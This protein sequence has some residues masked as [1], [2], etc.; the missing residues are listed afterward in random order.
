MAILGHLIPAGGGE[1]VP[2]TSGKITIGR[3]TEC[4]IVI[5]HPSVS[6]KHCQLLFR[7]GGL[8]VSPR[9]WQ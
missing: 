9:P 5:R 7:G 3:A 1:S 2:I 4:D 8:L 6:P